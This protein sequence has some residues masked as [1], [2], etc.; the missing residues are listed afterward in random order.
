MP[1]EFVQLTCGPYMKYS[2]Y[3]LK[4]SQHTDQAMG[5]MT[6]QL[7]FD[8]QHGQGFLLS[9]QLSRLALEPSQW[10]NNFPEGK[11]GTAQS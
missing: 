7:C 5:R 9:T 4:C 3:G 2:S 8:S 10:L 6:E 1:S 11:E